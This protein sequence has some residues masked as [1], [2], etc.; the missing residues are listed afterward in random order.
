MP[1]ATSGPATKQ[2]RKA[3]LKQAKGYYSGRRKLFKSAKETV[4]R[5]L[6]YAYRDRRQRRREFRSLWIVRINA[7]SRVYGMSYGHL[8]NGLKQAGVTVDRKILADLAVHDIEGFG[9]LVE[10]ARTALGAPIA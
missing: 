4:Q 5:A 7:A 9:R 6:R 10:T 3:I 2:R 1:R 8:M